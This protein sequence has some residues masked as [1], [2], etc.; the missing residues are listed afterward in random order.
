MGLKKQKSPANISNTNRLLLLAGARLASVLEGIFCQVLVPRAEGPGR[1]VAVEMM[2]ANAAVRNLIREG[3]IFQIPNT[4]RTSGDIG[5]R[6][7]DQP[8]I[9]LYQDNMISWD[10][11]LAFSQDREQVE[12]TVGIMG[13]GYTLR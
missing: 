10:N 2:L 4:M 6:L 11:L 13:A 5:M 3:K 12:R 8:L 9:T 1:A 7:L